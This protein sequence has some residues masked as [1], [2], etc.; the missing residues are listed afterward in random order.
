MYVRQCEAWEV[1]PFGPF[2]QS[3]RAGTPGGEERA[4]SGQQSVGKGAGPGPGL[5]SCTII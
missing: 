4:P 1:R 3:E 5:Q 2:L